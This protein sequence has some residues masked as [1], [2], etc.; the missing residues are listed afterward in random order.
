[1]LIIT[2]INVGHFNMIYI[3]PV[4]GLGNMFFHIASI[5]SLAKD[6]GDE[7][8]L[9]NIDK[10]IDELINDKRCNL[11]HANDY[12]FIFN[13]F[14]KTTGNKTKQQYPFKHISLKYIKEQEY[15]GYFQTEEYF[16]HRRKEILELLK[17]SIE[18]NNILE[19]YSDLFGNI[20]IHVRRGDFAIRYKGIHPTQS[21]DYY[22]Q[23]L[24]ILPK[25]KKI[26]IFSDDL[27]WCKTNFK[28]KRCLFIDE[29]DYISIYLMSKM[30]YHIIA[31]SSFSWW[32]AWL[33][34]YED[35]KVVAP[36]NW[37]GGKKTGLDEIMNIIPKNWIRI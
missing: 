1:M 18:I 23:A 30:K 28:D 7:L 29:I 20:S 21:I 3:H 17:P 11:K 37:F 12:K 25:D 35:K 15:V 36:N 8:C 16:K 2:Q 5:Y 33:S 10:K 6:N 31:N 26:L 34:E 19:K 32:G 4:G 13:R 9:L 22:N 24:N 14:H 27:E